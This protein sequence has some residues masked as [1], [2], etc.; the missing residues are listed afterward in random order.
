MSSYVNICRWWQP[1]ALEMSLT[2]TNSVSVVHLLC[3][4]VRARQKINSALSIRV[5]VNDSVRSK[6]NDSYF[7]YLHLIA[8]DA[9]S[10][11]NTLFTNQLKIPFSLSVFR[12][13]HFS[14]YALHIRTIIQFSNDY[15]NEFSVV[16]LVILW[17]WNSELWEYL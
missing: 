16:D 9:I 4:T 15:Y 10:N 14:N 8:I 6:L 1:F 17:A 7:W 11:S 3:T 2:F 5:I 12:L 13:S